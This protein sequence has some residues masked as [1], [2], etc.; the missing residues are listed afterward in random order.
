MSWSKQDE[1]S[2]FRRVRRGVY[3][4]FLRSLPESRAGDRM[5]SL[6]QFVRFHKRLPNKSMS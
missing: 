1:E 2:L 3:R 4:S 6:I 5:V